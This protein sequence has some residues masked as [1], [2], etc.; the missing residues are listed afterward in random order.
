MARALLVAADLLTAGDL[1]AEKERR[2]AGWS[3]G[4]G[5]DILGGR[6]SLAA[7]EER[8]VNE[9]IEPKPRSGGQERLEN[10]VNDRI[11]SADRER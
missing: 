4:I 10:V 9:G 2:Y 1:D 5:A 7:I 11:W 8:V 6:L 3:E